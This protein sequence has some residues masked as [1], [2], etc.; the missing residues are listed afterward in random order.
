MKPPLL[1]RPAV[2]IFDCDGVLLDSNTMKIAAF[3]TAL[4]GYPDGAVA[5]FSA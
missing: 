5:R 4:A 2:T 3:R 1:P